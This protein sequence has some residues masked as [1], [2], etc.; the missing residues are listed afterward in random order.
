MAPSLSS[1]TVRVIG[2]LV[3]S[4][5]CA[6]TA[7]REPR[8]PD[9]RPAL[10]WGLATVFV[11]LALARFVDVG[12]HLASIGR[13]EARRDGWYTTRR[14]FQRPITVV[15]AVAGATVAV[16]LLSGAAAAPRGVRRAL[17]VI[18]GSVALVSFAA[19]RA[20]SLHEV[21]SLLVRTVA[22]RSLGS[23]VEAALIGW[24]VVVAAS[25]ALVPVRRPRR[26]VS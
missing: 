15:V 22:G 16:A 20:I 17:P 24:C 1:D 9:A 4:G 25:A 5:A 3:V 21:D 19:V 23:L 11:M 2:Y 14:G 12:E 26:L 8:R 7:V 13:S 10:W 6:L 18:A